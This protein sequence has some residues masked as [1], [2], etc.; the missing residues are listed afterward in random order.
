MRCPNGH[1]VRT[2]AKFCKTCGAPVP[3]TE[4][5]PG[6]P[7]TVVGK[8]H[9]ADGDP[10]VD[11]QANTGTP[12]AASMTPSSTRQRRF[13]RDA[14]PPV[15]RSRGRSARG[16]PDVESAQQTASGRRHWPEG[17]VGVLLTGALLAGGVALGHVIAPPRVVYSVDAD[18]RP[19]S[20]AEGGALLT[21]PLMP[22]VTLLE[23]DAALAVLADVGV[24]ADAISVGLE[25]WAGDIDRVLLTEPSSGERLGGPVTLVLSTAAAVP[26]VSGMARDEAV[27]AMEN[28]GAVALVRSSYEPGAEPGTILAT[29][30]PAG[31]VL[32]AQIE[33]VVAG[34][35]EA[36]DLTEVPAVDSDNAGTT[37]EVSGSGQLF[38]TAWQLEPD[39]P[40]GDREP[41]PAF[42]E[43]SLGRHVD[44][45]E[46]TVAF[47]DAGATQG[48]LRLS[49]LG[50]GQQ[51]DA[52]AVGFG[53]SQPLSADV[54]G[55][56][57]LRL[58]VM[59]VAD[60]DEQPTLL[61]GEPRVVGSA[62]GVAQLEAAS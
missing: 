14:R 25:P 35:G 53:V 15:P 33:M 42:V 51:V 50:D 49:V 62:E 20:S 60:V 37:R 34:T 52:V 29:Q 4:A 46:G 5:V 19:T 59:P 2:G 28:L 12:D 54:R 26:D 13:R 39:S 45:L 11:D 56:L 57:R 17:A 18:A 27:A 38:A 21:P 6:L 3:S 8:G 40:S 1:E 9:E 16:S 58:E 36:L 31:Q 24:A 41:E 61:L 10:A 23:R 43:F 44:R 30:P 7:A 47:E 55:V 22:D 32:P 48:Q